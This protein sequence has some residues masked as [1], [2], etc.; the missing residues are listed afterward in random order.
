MTS[1]NYASCWVLLDCAFV[2][3]KINVSVTIY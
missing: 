2:D 3:N 1:L